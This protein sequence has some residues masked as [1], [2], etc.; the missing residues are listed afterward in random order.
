MKIYLVKEAYFSD[1]G[2]LGGGGSYG[3]PTLLKA[4]QKKSN[5]N[6]FLKEHKKKLIQTIS[7]CPP[8]NWENMSD[9]HKLWKFK[10]TIEPL[11]VT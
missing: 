5:A 7:K 6:K 2:G 4:F 9:A 8:P 11:E 1:D 3:E 10:F